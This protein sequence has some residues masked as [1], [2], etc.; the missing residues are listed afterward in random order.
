MSQPPVTLEL[1]DTLDVAEDVMALGHLRHIPVTVDGKLCG[2]VSQRDLLR[3]S[4][5][6]LLTTREE[7]RRALEGIRVREVAVCDV[8]TIGPDEPIAH[9]AAILAEKKI[10]CMPVV[11]AGELIGIVTETDLLRALAPGSVTVRMSEE[12][13][14]PT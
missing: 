6:S 9:A 11:L 13:E 12:P 1:D 14:W 8:V 7:Q 4:V 2:I 3:A 10:G 5:S